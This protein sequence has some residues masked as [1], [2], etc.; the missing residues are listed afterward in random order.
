MVA[1]IRTS[2]HRLRCKIGRWKKPKE[3]FK[4]GTC[5][6]CGSKDAEIEKYFFNRCGGYNEIKSVSLLENVSWT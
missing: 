2:S 3:Y 5:Q 4:H 6:V 1:H